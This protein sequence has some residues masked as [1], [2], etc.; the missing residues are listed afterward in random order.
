MLPLPRPEKRSKARLGALAGHRQEAGIVAAGRHGEE[1][2]Y[3]IAHCSLL[4][5]A[6]CLPAAP[7]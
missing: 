7:A 4:I 5:A 1:G 6:R 2:I 3:L